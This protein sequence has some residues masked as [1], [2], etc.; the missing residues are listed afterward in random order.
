MLWTAVTLGFGMN[1]PLPCFGTAPLRMLELP[2]H[3]PPPPV[4]EPYGSAA[5]AALRQHSAMCTPRSESIKRRQTEIL[6]EVKDTVNSSTVSRR[7]WTPPQS[8]PPSPLWEQH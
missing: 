6:V 4:P 1:T 5:M 3:T 8:T 2:T 7:E